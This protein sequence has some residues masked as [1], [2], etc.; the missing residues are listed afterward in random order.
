MPRLEEEITVA[1]QLQ[2]VAE[3]FDR[4]PDHSVMVSL[5]GTPVEERGHCFYHGLYGY[6]NYGKL[7]LRQFL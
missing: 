2:L 1:V 5:S 3:I 4:S 6:N 7:C